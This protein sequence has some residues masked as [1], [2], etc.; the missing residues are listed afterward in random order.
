MTAAQLC[1]LMVDSSTLSATPAAPNAGDAIALA[2]TVRNLGVISCAAAALTIYDGAPAEGAPLLGNVAIPALAPSQSASLSLNTTATA[3]TH[4]F[5]FIADE[6]QL[7][8]DADRSN[9]ISMLQLFV[10]GSSLSDLL[11]TS[12]A[13]APNP[14]YAAEPVTFSASVRNQGAPSRSTDYVLTS[15][16]AT[17]PVLASGSVPALGAGESAPLSFTLAAPLATTTLFLTVN[18]SG[19]VS[20]YNPNNNTAQLMLAVNDPGLVATGSANPSSAGPATTVAFTVRLQNTRAN[21]DA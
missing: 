4:L 7:T 5:R 15:G 1:D 11:I 13:A 16:S 9:N 14:A 17:G 21:F 19:Q 10:P 8:L 2:V 3:G 20:E 18:R 12:F 6:A